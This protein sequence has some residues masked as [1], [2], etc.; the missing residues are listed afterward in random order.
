MIGLDD[1]GAPAGRAAVGSRR[2]PFGAALGSWSS[3][4]HLA[5]SV[6]RYI[7]AAPPRLGG[8]RMLIGR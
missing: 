4:K 6:L 1:V 5:P 7:L 3:V 2:P 8:V